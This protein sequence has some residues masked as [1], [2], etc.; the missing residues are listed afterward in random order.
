MKRHS[1]APSLGHSDVGS[2][3]KAAIQF[4][5]VNV[6]WSALTDVEVA[7]VLRQQCRRLLT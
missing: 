4:A 3:Q 5:I 7:W 1:L 6:A 2:T